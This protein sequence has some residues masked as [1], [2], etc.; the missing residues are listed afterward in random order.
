MPVNRL[1]SDLISRAIPYIY[2]I[3]DEKRDP[4][5]ILNL[6][7]SVCC[8]FFAVAVVAFYSL[9]VFDISASSSICVWMA[10]MR[11]SE[12]ARICIEHF[13]SDCGNRRQVQVDFQLICYVF[14]FSLITLRR[15]LYLS[16]CTFF[17]SLLFSPLYLLVQLHCTI[18]DVFESLHSQLMPFSAFIIAFFFLL[19]FKWLLPLLVENVLTMPMQW[20]EERQ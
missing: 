18:L 12:R 4:C 6:F 14:S 19:L 8:C 1:V 10:L 13:L 17:F 2:K 7:F 9:S 20:R 3:N 11:A 16:M 15:C 5:V